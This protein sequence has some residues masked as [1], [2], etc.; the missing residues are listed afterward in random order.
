M[1]ITE[2]LDAGIRFLDVR[3]MLQYSDSPPVW[4]SLHMVESE[5]T[6]VQYFREIREWMDAHPSEIV[7][8]WVSKHGN[9]C[10]TG[11][12]QYPFVTVAQKR[13]YWAE[14]L[15]IF[16][17]LAV[18]FSVTKLNE[19]SINTM[20][21][22][23]HRAVFYVADYVE[24]TGYAE[25]MAGG[26][27]SSS[28]FALDSCLIDNQLGNPDGP[29]SVDWQ[30]SLYGEANARKTADKAEQRLYLVS[31]AGGMD[32]VDASLLKFSPFDELVDVPKVTQKCAATFD[33]PGMAW[34]PETL[35]DG[36]QL[37]NYYSQVAMDEVIEQMLANNLTLGLPHAIYINAIGSA[38]GT[39]RTGTEVLW[40][41][42]R[43]PDPTY[44]TQGF[45]YVDSFVLYNVLSVCKADEG[46]R[47][48]SEDCNTL[49]D[50]LVQRRA[51]NPL[52][53]WDDATY[54]RLKIW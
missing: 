30:R 25:D 40:G 22:R 17:G 10:A 11:D 36:S 12:D 54:G 24:M 34:C 29:S 6:S 27:E 21:E 44:A 14:I 37:A 49:T 2:Q 39:I 45:A 53:L 51:K 4:Y 18:D 3:T 9:N 42:N 50:L 19:T 8:M 38:Q 20:L 28:Y 52:S 7:V 48:P 16:D 47:A 31:L 5:G 26:A 13:D 33:T 32:Y 1:T 23:N 41:K 15:Q 46:R 35:L 43:S